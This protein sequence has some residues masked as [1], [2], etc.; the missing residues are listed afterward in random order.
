VR[1]G[2]GEGCGTGGGGGGGGRAEGQHGEEVKGL[3]GGG[4]RVRITPFYSWLPLKYQ[5]RTL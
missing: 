3:K 4:R 2:D 1:K 5:C